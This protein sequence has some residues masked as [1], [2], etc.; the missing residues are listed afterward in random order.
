M[1][2]ILFL[3]INIIEQKKV[4]ENEIYYKIKNTLFF[5]RIEKKIKETRQFII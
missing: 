5:L 4:K 1:I 2:T 3:L